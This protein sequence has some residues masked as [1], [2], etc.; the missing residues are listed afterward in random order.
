MVQF[1]DHEFGDEIDANPIYGARILV[2]GTF[3]LSGANRCRFCGIRQIHQ[4][5][6]TSRRRRNIQDRQKQHKEQS[7]QNLETGYTC[8]FRSRAMC[9]QFENT[10]SEN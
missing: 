8:A 9:L 5:K 1:C 10:Q 7:G 2:D 3:S 4:N 6:L